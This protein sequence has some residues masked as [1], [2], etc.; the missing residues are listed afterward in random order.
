MD[1]AIVGGSGFIGKSIAEFLSKENRVRIVDIKSPNLKSIDFKECDVLNSNFLEDC[2][3][4]CEVVIDS[5]IIQIPR[6]N[7]VKELAFNVNVIGTKNICEVCRKNDSKLLLLGTWHVYGE[8]PFEKT[9]IDEDYGYHLGKVSERAKFYV[10]N[11]IMQELMVRSYNEVY[12]IECGIL[13]LGTVLGEGMPE[14]TAASI[15]IN[16]AL[17]G[18][19]ITPFKSTR[20]RPMLYVDIND[21]K[22]AVNKFIGILDSSCETIHIAYPEPITII[23]LSELIK[24]LSNSTSVVRVVDNGE[25][26]FGPEDKKSCVLDLTR[27]KKKLGMENLISTEESLKRIIQNVRESSS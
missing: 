3:K 9:P 27:L 22:E 19:D 26:E 23:E 2:L 1:V 18:K 25:D 10:I 8:P 7:E 4:D 21:V 16:Q 6:I 17:N 12:G 24:R 11:K 20:Y 13:R 14:K 5:H 15:F